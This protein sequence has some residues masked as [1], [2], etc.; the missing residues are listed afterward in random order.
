MTERDELIEKALK[1]MKNLPGGELH[2]VAE[3]MADFALSVHGEIRYPEKVIGRKY[4]F[5][6]ICGW[7]DCIDEMKKLNEPP[8]KEEGE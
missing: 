6:Y 7:D 1:F 4:S 2:Y 5:S 3:T 8:R